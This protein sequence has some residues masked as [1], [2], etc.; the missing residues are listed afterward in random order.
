M[1]LILD[2]NGRSLNFAP[3]SLTRPISE[4][5]VGILTNAE[6]WKR[7]LPEAEISYRTQD[8]LQDKYPLDVNGVTVNACII[9][10]ESVVDAVRNIKP[11]ETVRFDG[12]WIAKSGM[13]E[14]YVE[15]KGE[16]P[17]EITERWHLY[18][19]NE[20][21]LRRDFE[22][23]T[24]GRKSQEI[25]STNMVIGD[26]SRIFL[27]E[28]VRM[29]AAILSPGEGYMYFGK[30]TEVMEGSIIKGSLAMCEGSGLKLGSKVYGATT[31]G[32]FCKV[33]GE[34]NNVVFTAYS[35]KG[36]E[37]FLGNSVIGEWCNIG[38]DTNTS[39]LKNNYSNV[40][41]YNYNTGKLEQTDIQFMGLMMGDHSKC[42]INTMFNTA[43]VVGVMS[44]IFGAGFPPKFVSNFQWGTGGEKFSFDKAI[45]SA[46]NMMKRRG[47]E[48][49]AEEVAILKHI[50]D[51][52]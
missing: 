24:K 44:N 22:L 11:N 25:S 17:L 37:G 9:P 48:L 18:Q 31:L 36:H 4:L 32:P 45:E 5:R 16:K 41:T 42:G 46:N 10:D 51:N 19:K 7:F 2:D 14:V 26:A 3:L 43:T 6:R 40:K 39:N 12:G 49:S 13:G 50:S 30:N 47:K 20:E 1:K 23:I 15:H 28:G 8:H 52:L 27:E 21:V 38:A 29:E 34:V 33:G 35:N